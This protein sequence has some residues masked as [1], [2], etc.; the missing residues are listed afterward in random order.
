LNAVSQFSSR[1]RKAPYAGAHNDDLPTKEHIAQ[2]D[3]LPTKE[4]VDFCFPSVKIWAPIIEL[5]NTSA[6]MNLWQGLQ[7]RVGPLQIERGTG[8]S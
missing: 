7:G 1:H 8:M 2:N 3:D 5:T 6:E 4:H